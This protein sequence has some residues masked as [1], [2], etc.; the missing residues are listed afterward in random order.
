VPIKFP[1][2]RGE[3]LTMED[4]QKMVGLWLEVRGY[5]ELYSRPT[6]RVIKE[7]TNLVFQDMPFL[8]TKFGLPTYLV[9]GWIKSYFIKVG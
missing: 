9:D 5:A 4:L 8:G 2:R 3:G 7:L 6:D 1:E